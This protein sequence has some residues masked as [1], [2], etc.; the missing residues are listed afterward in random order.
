MREIAQLIRVSSAA[1]PPHRLAPDLGAQT[2]QILGSLGF[3]ADE[4]AAWRENGAIR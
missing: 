4:V 2:D 3:G 1:V